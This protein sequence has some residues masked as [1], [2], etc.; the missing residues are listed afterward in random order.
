MSIFG[1]G[2]KSI[3][4]D[5]F[6]E[7]V[8][9]FLLNSSF[10]EDGF[11]DIAVYERSFSSTNLSVF[12]REW[13]IYQSFIMTTAFS[14]VFKDSDEGMESHIAYCDKIKEMLVGI[15]LFT[16]SEDCLET[17]TNRY[18]LYS[19]EL[20]EN[21]EPNYIYWI[22]KRF[23]QHVGIHDDLEAIM[24]V[25]ASFPNQVKASIE[26]L[27]SLTQKVKLERSS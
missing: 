8:A 1:F 4:T 24:C 5:E 11:K 26:L 19:N 14:S 17:F 21:R 18:T 16:S 12:K 15:G 25:S 6:G 10:D 9:G 13:M 22:S 2:K 3:S 7:L 23:C 27:N 20:A